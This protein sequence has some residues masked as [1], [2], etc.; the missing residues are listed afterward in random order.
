MAQ[1]SLREKANIQATYNNN[2]TPLLLAAENRHKQ[3]VKLLL[4]KG[5]EVNVQGGVY[6]NALQAASQGGHKAVVKLLVAW[7]AKSS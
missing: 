4:D 5:A 3:V 2:K 6:G 7:G 1:K